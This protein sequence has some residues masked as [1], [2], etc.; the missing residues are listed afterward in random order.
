MFD[1][2]LWPEQV[3]G[4]TSEKSSIQDKAQQ[5]LFDLL[6]VM[7][8]VV[9]G[10]GRIVSVNKSGARV[11]GY[12]AS[13]LTGKPVREIFYEDDRD[14]VERQVARCLSDPDSVIQWEFRKIRRDDSILWVRE[15]AKAA[16]QPD[17]SYLIHI[18]CEDIT[19]NRAMHEQLTQAE[20]KYRTLIEQVP[21]VSYV[22]ELGEQES[23]TTFISPQ[24]ELLL[25][26]TPSEWMDNPLFW[27]TCTYPADR[28]RIMEEVAQH[29]ESGEAFFLE[30]RAITKE[31][32]VRWIRNH[33]EYM[34]D[35]RGRPSFVHGVMIDISDTKR[36][37]EREQELQAR[38]TRAERMQSLGLLAGGVAHDLNNIL[39]PLVGF[40]DLILQ[41]LP[42]DHPVAQDVIMMRDSALRASGVIQDLLTLAR[43]G[44]VQLEPTA[45]NDVVQ[46]YLNSA[47]FASI[48][49]RHPGVEVNAELTLDNP[50]I[51]GAA[52]PLNQTIM[53][54]IVNAMESI[55]GNGRV[56]VSTH[57]EQVAM[58]VG[59]FDT[60]EPGRYAVLRVQD[61]GCGIS[62]EDANH[63]F[64][65]FYSSKKMGRSGTGLGLSI[66]YG[67]VRDM[68]G[69]IDVRSE[70]GVGTEFMLYF[71]LSK[72]GEITGP[73]EATGSLEGDGRILVVDDVREQRELARRILEKLG[74][75]VD[76]ASGM[77]EALK[78][79]QQY[80]YDL[81]V[82]DMIIENGPDGLDIYKALLAMA[83]RQRCVLISG[84]AETQ[85]VAEARKL[86]AG[87]YVR[88][89]YTIEK[90]GRAVRAEMKR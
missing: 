39:G 43:R 68:H 46:R 32:Q 64:E 41:E 82:L 83:P 85:R 87:E 71:P 59:R 84:Y 11:M 45:L 35:Q 19:N 77:E 74:Y 52:S 62:N 20:M 37:E 81:L 29:N 88:K 70:P 3:M 16:P 72:E 63:I 5:V 61:T 36:I 48:R 14:H 23:P 31:G 7:Y 6:P 34:R 69:A 8:F 50:V 17:G 58:P 1:A 30:Y 21:A 27:I 56:K 57:I 44:N 73:D 55:K 79:F 4:V 78:A 25:G 76:T 9:D 65:P 38:L 75:T 86:G 60:V 90:L 51:Y 15:T 47:E 40:P 54:L 66:V 53:N 18:L 89:P 2:L 10:D 12:A 80:R 67:V 42:D 33:G 24:I 49:T 13:E 22:V 28:D 26:Y